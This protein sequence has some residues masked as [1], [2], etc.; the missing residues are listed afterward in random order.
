MS[1]DSLIE[2]FGNHQI[3][4]IV[5]VVGFAVLV[6]FKPKPMVQLVGVVLLIGA[7]GYVISFLVDLTST[8]IDHTDSFM[9]NP[10][11]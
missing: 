9:S 6:Y 11:K 1:I 7:I 2:L 4:A 3:L 8:G 10:G 5:V